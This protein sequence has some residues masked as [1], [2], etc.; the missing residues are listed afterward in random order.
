MECV[1]KVDKIFF[2]DKYLFSLR[3]PKIKRY[4]SVVVVVVVDW[5]RAK[6]KNLFKKTK[7]F[8]GVMNRALVHQWHVLKQRNIYQMKSKIQNRFEIVF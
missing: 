1:F 4:I 2:I 7:L 5:L 6:S 3:F 8:V